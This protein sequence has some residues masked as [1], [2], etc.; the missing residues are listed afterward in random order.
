MSG[1]S[2]LFERYKKSDIFNIKEFY[3]LVGDRVPK[4]MYDELGKLEKRLEK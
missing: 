4:K 1:N 3:A 2:K